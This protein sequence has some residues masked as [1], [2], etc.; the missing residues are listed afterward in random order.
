MESRSTLHD[1]LP[2]RFAEL[3]QITARLRERLHRAEAEIDQLKVAAKAIGINLE[4]NNERA[5]QKAEIKIAET[6]I[7]NITMKE[8]ALRILN[9]FDNGLTASEIVEEMKSRFGMTYP[10]SSLSPQLSRL[11]HDG[12][13]QQSGSRWL[14]SKV[15]P[16]PTAQSGDIF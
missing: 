14:L 12:L 13:L 1:F 8:A 9:D 4:E 2:L 6:P 7:I 3:S 11:K 15:S 5:P 16:P 10:R